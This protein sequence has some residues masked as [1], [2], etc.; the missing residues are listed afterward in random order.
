MLLTDRLFTDFDNRD[1]S[2]SQV[3]AE[4]MNRG[5]NYSMG[6]AGVAQLISHKRQ[7]HVPTD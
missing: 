2:F 5:R 7:L 3:L 4:Q 6:A 1:T